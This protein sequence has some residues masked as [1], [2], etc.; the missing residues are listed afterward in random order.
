[1]VRAAA[2]EVLVVALVV[3]TV[4]LVPDAAFSW[5]VPAALVAAAGLPLRLRWPWVA[6]L[7]CLPAVAGGLG[8]WAALFALFRVGRT[9]QIVVMVPWVVA[10]VVSAVVPVLLTQALPVGSVL[11]TVMFACGVA[12]APVG[13]GALVTTRQRLMESLDAARRARSAELDARED[14]ARAAERARIA[15]EIHDAVG[16]HATLIAVEAAALAATSDDEQTRET[17]TRLRGLAKESLAEMRHALGL[18]NS[19]REPAQGYGDLPELVERARGAGLS[20]RLDDRGGAEL[21]P[22]VGRAVFRVVQEALTNVTKHAPGAAVVVR[23]DRRGSGLRVSVVNGPAS[24]GAL[25][26][27][28]GGMGLHGLRERVRMLGGTLR[29]SR[30]ADGGFAVE[31]D[32]PTGNA[33]KVDGNSSTFDGGQRDSASA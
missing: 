18:L 8:W 10:T 26:A 28:V 27:D 6:A 32:L 33:A 30:H 7:L 13:L 23:L 3:A 4:L 31:A 11:L 25:G 2:R 1:V 21:P 24:A 20:V 17:A 29:T 22:A 9:S 16:H 12:A 5:S 19:P 14:S 15:R